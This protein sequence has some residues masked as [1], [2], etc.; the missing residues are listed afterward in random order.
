MRAEEDLWTGRIDSHE[1][2]DSFRLHQVVEQMS[3]DQL[4][5]SDPY[6]AFIGFESDEGVRRNKGRQG[7]SKAPDAIRKHLAKIPNHFNTQLIDV[8]NVVCEGRDL[9]EAQSSLGNQVA[10]LLGSHGTPIILGGGHETLYGH[11][12]GA[13]KYLGADQSLGIINIDAHF[14]LR[15]DAEPS[16][17]TMFRQILEQDPKA[18]YLCLGVQRFGNTPALFHTA[19]QLDCEYVLEEELE[20]NNFEDTF[21]VIDT[22]SD[23]FDHIILTAMYRFDYCFIRARC[24]CSFADRYGPKT[25]KKLLHHISRRK[26]LLSFD[27][28]VVNPT[29]DHDE[30]TVR[31]A[32]YLV[33]EVMAGMDS[34]KK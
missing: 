28:S 25:V 11:Y 8:G 12:L 15:N 24:Q 3:V 30:Q 6:F 23:R 10:K 22:F 18:G 16:S 17:G 27:I 1:N 7:A 32:S 26:N 14:D 4:Q 29:L 13:R 20:H 9:E 19:D 31:L 2:P 33:A 21:N 5:D 34:W